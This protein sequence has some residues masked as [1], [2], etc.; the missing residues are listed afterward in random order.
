[1]RGK[2]NNAPALMPGRR[3]SIIFG[4]S[5]AQLMPSV[6][7]RHRMVVEDIFHSN[8]RILQRKYSHSRSPHSKGDDDPVQF[9]AEIRLHRRGLSEA[10]PEQ[11]L[12]YRADGPD[13]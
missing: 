5:V 9:P 12:Q 13:C 10:A 6:C 3:H 2:I 8:F 1:M 11:R 7:Q 4:P